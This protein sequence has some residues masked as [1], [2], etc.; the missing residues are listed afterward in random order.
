MRYYVRESEIEV[1]LSRRNLL[2]GLHKLDMPGSYRELQTD[3]GDD[4]RV[5]R[6]RFE[7]DADHYAHPDR[8]APKIAGPMHPDT[9]KF[10]ASR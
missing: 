7:D 5:L 10:I 8:R 3:D 2:A 6:V 9:E 4:P 1:V